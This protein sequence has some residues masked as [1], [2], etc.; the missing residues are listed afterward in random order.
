MRSADVTAGVALPVDRAE[1]EQL[2]A[3]P[4]QE[5]VHVREERLTFVDPG[6]LD[7]DFHAHHRG[8]Q[9][10]RRPLE[11]QQLAA[12]R[13]HLDEVDILHAAGVE[14]VVERVRVHLP[15]LDGVEAIGLR[16]RIEKRAVR[17][18]DRGEPAIARDVQAQRSPAIVQG[19]VDER[20]G[21]LLRGFARNQLIEFPLVGLEADQVKVPAGG[22]PVAFQ[23]AAGADVDEDQRVAAI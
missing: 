13:V 14:H 6:E 5:R 17:L 4:A 19:D 23:A 15:G 16:E 12:L 2:V 9:P 11:H 20:R 1:I 10:A 8:H 7:L 21:A 18:E 3:E 22:D